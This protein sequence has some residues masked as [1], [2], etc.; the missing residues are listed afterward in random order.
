MANRIIKLGSILILLLIPLVNYAAEETDTDFLRI[1]NGLEV[2]INASYTGTNNGCVV[3]VEPNSQEGITA[4]TG[5]FTFDMKVKRNSSVGGDCYEERKAQFL[6]SAP[7][8]DSTMTIEC[9]DNA[10]WGRFINVTCNPL[11]FTGPVNLAVYATGGQPERKA[12]IMINR[13]LSAKAHQ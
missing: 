1:G 13:Q 12:A 9:I 2:P 4:G 3:G 5:F 11:S 6:V 7:D 8:L 10:K